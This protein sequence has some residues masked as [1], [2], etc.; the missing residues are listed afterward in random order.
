[1]S[2]VNQTQKSL[3]GIYKVSL[4]L[5][6]V[7]IAL[8]AIAK[9]ML[10]QPE[11]TLGLFIIGIWNSVIAYFGLRVGNNYAISN[12]WHD[13]SKLDGWGWI[14]FSVV[15]MMTSMNMQNIY[16]DKF[17]SFLL[18]WSFIL[19][20]P[21]ICVLIISARR[22]AWLAGDEIG[23]RSTFLRSLQLFSWPVTAR[24]ILLHTREPKRYS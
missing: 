1:M 24:Y 20:A 16:A 22:L 14:L 23:A 18:P 17:E 5:I 19:A 4:L 3:K 7:L 12:G 6:F 21:L 9:T 11:D 2:A 15:Q 8:M 10:G 13:V